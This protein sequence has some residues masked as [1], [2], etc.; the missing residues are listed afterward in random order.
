[1]IN[2]LFAFLSEEEN[3][4]ILK[5]S[6]IIQLPIVIIQYKCFYLLTQYLSPFF[7]ITIVIK[8]NFYLFVFHYCVLV[9]HSYSS[10]KHYHVNYS[11][12]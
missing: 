3:G 12:I 5:I 11:S 1:M 8:F 2:F 4:Q 6:I 7:I 10:N 9:P